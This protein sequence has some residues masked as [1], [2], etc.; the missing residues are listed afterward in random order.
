MPH[1]VELLVAESPA[2][3]AISQQTVWAVPGEGLRGDRYFSGGGTFSPHP[4]KADFEITLIQREH[5]EAF[6]S[7]SGI[8]FR[9]HDARRNVVTLG[10]DLNTLVGREFRLGPVLIRGIRL[11]EPC[12]YLAKQTSPEVLKG[13]LHKGG[14]RAQILSEGEIKVGDPVLA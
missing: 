8:P 10:I 1:I 14:L 4:Q 3:P 6:A 13:L 11:C 9:A 5:V 2:S 12:A 7:T